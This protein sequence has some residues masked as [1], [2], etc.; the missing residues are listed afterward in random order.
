[1]LITLL[2]LP[3]IRREEELLDG[4]PGEEEATNYDNFVITLHPDTMEHLQLSYSTRILPR[5]P[6]GPIHTWLAAQLHGT[7]HPRPPPTYG[8]ISASLEASPLRPPAVHRVSTSLEDRGPTLGERASS[9]L[10]E[11]PSTEPS[12]GPRLGGNSASLEATPRQME[13]ATHLLTRPSDR[14]IKCQPLHHRVRSQSASG[15]HAA[16]RE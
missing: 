12:A 7:A 2:G 3:L 10:L 13:L 15:H 11:A 16:Q 4:D 8:T 9:A 5:L 14:G 1:M 6:R